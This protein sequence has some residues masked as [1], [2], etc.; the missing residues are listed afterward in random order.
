MHRSRGKYPSGAGSA[1]KTRSLPGC[2]NFF[3]TGCFDFFSL[4]EPSGKRRFSTARTAQRSLL[5]TVIFSIFGIGA[6]LTMAG[7][8]PVTAWSALVALLQPMADLLGKLLQYLMLPV[9]YL[10]AFLIC[11]I[12]QFAESG[13]GPAAGVCSVAD[14]WTDSARTAKRLVL[15]PKLIRAAQLGLVAVLLLTAAYLILRALFGAARRGI[16]TPVDETHDFYFS[17]ALL[18]GDMKAELTGQTRVT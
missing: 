16:K 11:W 1:G 12:R 8:L 6:T 3:L 17:W 7:S 13:A 5:F 2:G 18:A 14:E 4:L 10:I 15:S 9:A